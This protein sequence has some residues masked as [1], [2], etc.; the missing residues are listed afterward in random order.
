MLACAFVK[1]V[2]VNAYKTQALK[3]RGDELNI[4]ILQEAGKTFSSGGDVQSKSMK[5]ALFSFEL[6]R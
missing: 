5:S 2:R 1:I 4:L 6:A 3:E